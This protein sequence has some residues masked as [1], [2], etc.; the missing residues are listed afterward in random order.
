M[1][2]TIAG[3]LTHPGLGAAVLVDKESTDCTASCLKG[4][5]CDSCVT[6]PPEGG[7]CLTRT[8]GFW[9]NHPWITNDY[10]TVTVCSQV[11]GCDD[12][13]TDTSACSAGYCHSIIEGLCSNPSELSSNQPY[14]SMV[15]QLTAA[16]LN[17]NATADLFAGATCA[18]FRYEG[19]TI[20]QWI[21]TCG[22]LCGAD[23]ATISG[24]HCIEALTAFNS[25]QDVGFDQTPSP[26][27]RPSVDDNGNVKGA[28][29]TQCGLAQGNS[30]APKFVVGKKVGSNDCS[31]PA[32]H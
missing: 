22:T 23:K 4:P 6:P 15:R 20:Q 25:D 12:I 11:L 30:G 2:L 24:S 31:N 7:A 32:T 29:P 9:G 21:S 3:E 16:N 14:V 8:I 27:D 18:D 28:D 1:T 17:L 13:A 19:K 5:S 26:F 10:D